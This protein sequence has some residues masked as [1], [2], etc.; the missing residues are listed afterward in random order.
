MACWSIVYCS[1]SAL[2]PRVAALDA[3]PNIEIRIFNPFARRKSRLLDFVI[4][5]ARV[6]H[7]MHNK[8]MIL[9]NAVAI[10][11]G[12]NIGDH[13]FD[14]STDANFRDLDIAAAGPVVRDISGVFDREAV[15]IGSFNLDP[16]SGS[17]DTEA[18]LYVE[19][20]ELAEQ[21]IAYMDE[22]VQA[23]NSYRVLLDENGELVWITEIDGRE[24]RYHSDPETSLR[25]RFISGSIMLLPVEH[26]L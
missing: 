4:D 7:R 26:Q 9:D 17:I 12:R 19:S 20:P 1:C 21:V 11:G 15:F 10:V 18:A 13:Y 2:Y 3:H 8:T 24:V 16:R 6:N 23:Q 25:Q 22:G 5:L 14:V